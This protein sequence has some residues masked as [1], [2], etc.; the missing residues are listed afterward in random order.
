MNRCMVVDNFGKMIA[1]SHAEK[2]S[3]SWMG[4]IK[5]KLVTANFALSATDEGIVKA[6]IQGDKIVETKKFP[7]TEPFVDTETRLFPATGG[8]F[9]VNQ[10]EIFLLKI[11]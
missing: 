2:G 11:N 3:D 6:E 5:G 10:H 1:T 9:A 7:D 4:K 8:I